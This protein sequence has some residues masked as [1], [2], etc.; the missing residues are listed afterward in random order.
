MDK[1]DIFIWEDLQT[2]Q[3]QGCLTR[4]KRKRM[5]LLLI[6]RQTFHIP[7]DLV[8]ERVRRALKAS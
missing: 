5:P 1:E 2:P 8:V 6:L 3:D 7:P 4:H